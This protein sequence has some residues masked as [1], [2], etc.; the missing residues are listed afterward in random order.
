MKKKIAATLTLSFAFFL[1]G[2]IIVACK[3]N[4]ENVKPKGEDSCNGDIPDPVYFKITSLGSNITDIHRNKYVDTMQRDFE[5]VFID[6]FVTGESRAS[7]L[8]KLKPNFSLFAEAYACS[9]ALRL[10][11]PVKSIAIISKSDL[12][13]NNESDSIS[14]GDTITN[15]FLIINSDNSSN[16]ISN[17][18][19]NDSQ[20]EL[21][22]FTF[23]LKDKPHQPVYLKADVH[24]RLTDSTL[25]VLEGQVLNVN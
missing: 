4:T 12:T 5:T 20:R 2:I 11:H 13:Y 8:L 1:T 15:R 21:R 3:K 24:V 16:V 9:P 10:L 18:F 23:R 22:S 19:L 14:V 17:I 6:V 25:F 7:H